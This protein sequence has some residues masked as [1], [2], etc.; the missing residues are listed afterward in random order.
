MK[1]REEVQHGTMSRDR[2]TRSGVILIENDN[3]ALIKRVRFDETYYVFP[4]GGIEPGE[5]AEMAAVREA[6]EEL[7][8]RVELGVLAAIV[9]LTDRRYPGERKEQLYYMATMREGT[10][11]TGSGPEWTDEYY[12]TR[13]TYTPVW[14]HINNLATY[15]IRP[16]KLA[17]MIALRS[18]QTLPISIKEML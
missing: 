1:R 14:I 2:M 4:G 6:Y 7:G 12:A 9:E 10:F 18:L 17:E 5:T 8:V 3:L 13:G 15:T 11:G 16:A